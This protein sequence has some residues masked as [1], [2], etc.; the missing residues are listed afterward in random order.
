MLWFCSVIFTVREL[1]REG[2]MKTLTALALVLGF[3]MRLSAE[4]LLTDI[5]TYETVVIDEASGQTLAAGGPWLWEDLSYQTLGGVMSGPGRSIVVKCRNAAGQTIF[6]GAINAADLRPPFSP[7]DPPNPSGEVTLGFYSENYTITVLLNGIYFV[8]EMIMLPAQDDPVV[9]TVSVDIK[10]GS[11]TNPFNIRSEG[12]LPVAILGS[13]KVNVSQVDL[14]SIK[15]AGITPVRS[16]VSDLQGDGYADL[17][18]HFRNQD[19][20]GVLVGVTDGE[21]VG[22]ELTG[23]LLDG[24][25]LKGTDSITV[26]AKQG[27]KDK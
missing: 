4:P 3:A 22:L 2:I 12:L 23:V 8:G 6:G 24:T 20:A 5:V 18:L 1:K 19:L 25:V 11:V 9:L 10:P 27:K 14:T 17:V 26:M 7:F 21:V 16:A 15:L 13:P